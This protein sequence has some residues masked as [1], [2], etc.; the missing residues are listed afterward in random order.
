MCPDRIAPGR[1]TLLASAV[2]GAIAAV[3]AGTPAH[4]QPSISPNEDL[5]VAIVGYGFIGEGLRNGAEVAVD[6]INEAG[7]LLGHKLRV[8]MEDVDLSGLTVRTAAISAA[9]RVLSQPG[10]IA[11]IGHESVQDALPA[12]ITYGRLGIPL[13]APTIS[14]TGLTQHGLTNLFATMPDN[15]EI[16]VQTARLAFDIGLRRAVIL[17]D[18]TADSLEVSLAYRDEAAVLGITVV[19][20]RS[21]P[22]GSS[23]RD[24]MTRLQGE[25]FDHL[26]LIGP[27]KLQT[28]LVGM[29]DDLGLD[30]TSVMPVI[31]N[32]DYVQSQ[33]GKI[34]GRVLMPVLRDR[35][36]PSQAQVKWIKA[37]QDRFGSPPL[38]IS[39]QGTDAVG[40][41][42]EGLKRVG[43]IDLV[44]LGRVLHTEFAYTGVGGRISFR[45]NG[46]VYTRLLGFASIRPREVAYYM[47]GA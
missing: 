7:G 12:A 3:A 33:L 44:E 9:K 41:L 36:A 35:S 6:Q 2:G 24:F 28:A 47:P 25:R 26:L 19:E 13:I 27:L 4:A 22:T 15:S 17:R 14:S 8:Y 45:R 34:K 30:V 18:R 16:S 37:Y 10:L 40:L 46:R 29:A 39:I 20:E 21:L 42:A 38:D 23:P 31:N 43:S 32:P 11:V 5:T 1:R